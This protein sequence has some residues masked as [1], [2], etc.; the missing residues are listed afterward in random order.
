MKLLPPCLICFLVGS[1]PVYAD[2]CPLEPPNLVKNSSFECDGINS[3]H[4]ISPITGW[5]VNNTDIGETSFFDPVLV[6]HAE[7]LAI[8]TVGKLGIVSQTISTVY[9]Q[10]YTFTFTFSSDGAEGNFF[11]AR[12]GNQVVM[13]ADSMSF[14][15]GWAKFNGSAEYSFIV[16]ATSTH[17]K[18]SFRGEGNGTSCIGVDDVS[19]TPTAQ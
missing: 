14:R 4:L 19:V 16:T 15:P 18:I 7:Y 9:G 3:S 11:Q 5:T 1:V 10:S 6:G 13:E 17:T 2:T 12:W 8:C